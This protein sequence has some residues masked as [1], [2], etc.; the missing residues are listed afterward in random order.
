VVERGARHYE[1]SAVERVGSIADGVATALRRE[2]MD[3]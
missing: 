2:K 3:G 1:G